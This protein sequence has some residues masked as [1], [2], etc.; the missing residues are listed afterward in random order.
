MLAEL[1]IDNKVLLVSCNITT[2][3]IKNRQDV[4]SV[5]V[6]ELEKTSV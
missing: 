6:A 5:C 4:M 1:D 2:E 3:Y